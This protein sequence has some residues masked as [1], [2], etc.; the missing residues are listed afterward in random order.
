MSS[1][2]NVLPMAI[3]VV[4]SLTG[5]HKTKEPN[6]LRDRLLGTWE[7]GLNNPFQQS[8]RFTIR[9]DVRDNDSIE[10]SFYGRAPVLS[11][12]T[13]KDSTLAIDGMEEMWI[14]NLTDSTLKLHPYINDMASAMMY[15]VE[16]QRIR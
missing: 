11:H 1:A 5:C 15:A 13:V 7:G 16:Y 14:L 10:M 4:M 8:E 6:P 3:I 2:C 9:L 12:Y